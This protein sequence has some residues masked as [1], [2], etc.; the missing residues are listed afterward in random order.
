MLGRNCVLFL[1]GSR[2]YKVEM[3]TQSNSEEITV[4][5]FNPISFQK[6]V[7]EAFRKNIK[8]S[9]ESPNAFFIGLLLGVLSLFKF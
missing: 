8:V 3:L 4:M 5:K 1:P 7:E 6:A 9:N 2:S